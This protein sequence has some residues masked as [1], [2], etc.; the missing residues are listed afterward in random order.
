MEGKREMRSWRACFFWAVVEA[1]GVLVR[2]A[3]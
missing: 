3:V 2:M 1:V